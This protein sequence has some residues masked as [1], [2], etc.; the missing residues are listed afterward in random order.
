MT[1]WPAFGEMPADCSHIHESSRSLA[2][3][4]KSAEGRA[5]ARQ[6]GGG[7]MKAPPRSVTPLAEHPV[8]D[9]VEI[10][11]EQSEQEGIGETGHE[12]KL[13]SM[14]PFPQPGTLHRQL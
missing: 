13:A 7:V 10:R 8:P 3:E 9:R 4:P 2:P 12:Q 1:S 6:R 11:V 5:D 14:F